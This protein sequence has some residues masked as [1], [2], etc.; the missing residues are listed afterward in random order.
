MNA[1]KIGGNATRGGFSRHAGR[2]A[3]FTAFR[4]SL[5]STLTWTPNQPA[6]VVRWPVPE[7]KPS[8]PPAPAVRGS[9]ASTDPSTQRGVDSASR[10]PCCDAGP[11]FQLHSLPEDKTSL[12]QLLA[13]PCVAACDLPILFNPAEGLS[14]EKPA[15]ASLRLPSKFVPLGGIRRAFK[16]ASGTSR[17]PLIKRV[18]TLCEVQDGER[19]SVPVPKPA[20]SAPENRPVS[21]LSFGLLDDPISAARNSGFPVTPGIS[22]KSDTNRPLPEN[23][24]PHQ[25]WAGAEKRPANPLPHPVDKSILWLNHAAFGGAA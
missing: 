18:Y 1:R 20:L 13:R 11:R 19:Q 10:L 12:C 15:R 5:H 14:M 22:A 6:Q 2:A 8:I 3:A 21:G 25:Y 7:V 9:R 17:K 4:Q 23:R 16:I 24:I